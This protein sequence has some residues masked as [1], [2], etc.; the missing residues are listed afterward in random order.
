MAYIISK[1]QTVTNILIVKNE[2]NGDV[3]KNVRNNNRDNLHPRLLFVNRRVIGRRGRLFF[4]FSFVRL[5]NP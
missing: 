4:T 1:L 2:Y 3:A 5:Q